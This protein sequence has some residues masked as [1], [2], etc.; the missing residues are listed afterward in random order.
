MVELAISREMYAAGINLSIPT[1]GNY[2]GHG[3]GDPTGRKTPIG[4]LDSIYKSHDLAPEYQ[5]KTFSN[6]L[7]YF[8]FSLTPAD[9]ALVKSSDS[10]AKIPT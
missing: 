6:M 10:L 5:R 4:D 7:D 2:G 8:D 3:H 1:Y 9:R